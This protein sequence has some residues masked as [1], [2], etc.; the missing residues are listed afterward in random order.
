MS[1]TDGVEPN[2][3]DDGET[4]GSRL[5]RKRRVTANSPLEEKSPS[6][7]RPRNTV[8]PPS[9]RA[10][11]TAS[12]TSPTSKKTKPRL[13]STKVPAAAEPALPN[14]SYSD[15]DTISQHTEP[16]Q[17]HSNDAT[18]LQSS[19]K[20][21]DI[22]EKMSLH[23]QFLHVLPKFPASKLKMNE[24]DEVIKRIID[25]CDKV[26][27]LKK[28]DQDYGKGG[29]DTE[30][31]PTMGANTALKAAGLAVL[32]NL[33]VQLLYMFAVMNIPDLTWIIR[34]PESEPGAVCWCTLVATSRRLTFYHLVL[35]R[36]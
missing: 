15:S 26:K 28:L 6:S 17:E 19:S 1:I 32:E 35:P 30:G 36:D 4:I 31:L 13:S 25:H 29:L 10:S 14:H 3:S 21:R 23:E 33:S 20:Q 24:A 16:Q 12:R 22:L 27:G 2:I 9:K 18:K 11:P 8:T 34:H 5:R 7:K